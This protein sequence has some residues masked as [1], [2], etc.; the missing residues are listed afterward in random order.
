MNPKKDYI[1]YNYRDIANVI[2]EKGVKRSTIK[3]TL[4][5]VGEPL[6]LGDLPNSDAEK[7]YGI[8]GENIGRS[9]T[10]SATE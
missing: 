3:L 8:I 10:A 4:R 7:A 9:K 6:E 5:L 2:M 1:D